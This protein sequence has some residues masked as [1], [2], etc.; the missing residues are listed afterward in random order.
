MEK[1]ACCPR[2]TLDPLASHY[3]GVLL[4]YFVAQTNVV[5]GA[6]MEPTLHERPTAHCGKSELSA[7][8][9][10]R[11]DVVVVDVTGLDVPLIKRVVGLPGETV[12]IRDNQVWVNGRVLS[13]PY[14]PPL[15]QVNYPPTQVPPNFVFL[16]G[17]NRPVS[18]DFASVWR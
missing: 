5:L 7:D 12:E 11:G 17:D 14:L 16:M 1:S 8:H 3:P 6:S 2:N 9:P 10:Q 4:I 13:E 15:W 18:R